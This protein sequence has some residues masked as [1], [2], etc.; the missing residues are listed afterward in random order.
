MLRVLG[1][2]LFT[3]LLA[4]IAV[5]F[6]VHLVPGDP[7]QVMLGEKATP[8]AIATVR[9]E[10]GLDRP[11]LEQLGSFFVRLSQGDLGRSIRSGHPVLEEVSAR[12]PATAELS[13]AAL[14]IALVVGIL[15]GMLAAKKPGGLMDLF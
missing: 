14:L 1:E 15:L 7:A 3:I 13:I 5:F 11:I 6:L 8:E 12:L 2:N 10:L 9:Q 4:V